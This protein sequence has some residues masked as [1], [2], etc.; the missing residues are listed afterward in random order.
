DSW[1]EYEPAYVRTWNSQTNFCTE[2]KEGTHVK[3]TVKLDTTKNHPDAIAA[4]EI[5]AN[6]PADYTLIPVTYSVQEVQDT[7]AATS[8]NLNKTS[9][10]LEKSKTTTLTATVNPSNA[11]NKTVTWKSSN[12]KVATVDS[13]GKIKAVGSGSAT[14][15]AET[16][17]GKKATCKVTVKV[18]PTSIKLNKTS[19][20]IVKGKTA[21]ITA[22]V[23]PSNATD[24]KVT[25]KSS[26]TKVATVDSTGKITAKGAGTATITA[27]TSNSK[28]A[29]C[30]VTVNTPPTGVKLNKTSL[31]IGKGKTATLKATVNPT[32]NVTSKKVT[33]SSS[34]KS[35][36]TVNS[37]GKITAK[38]VGTTTITVKTANG[39]TAKCKVTVKNLPSKVKLNKTKATIESDGTVTLKA[40]VSPS[41]V[42]SKKV[43]WTSSNKKVAT[44]NSKGKVTAKKPGTVTIT[45]KTVNGKT[46][47]CKVTVKKIDYVN[48]LKTYIDKHSNGK[49]NGNKYIKM[50]QKLGTYNTTTYII[51]DKSSKKPK[52]RFT[53]SGT[54]PSNYTKATITTEYYLG[55]STVKPNTTADYTYPF[56]YGFKSSSSINTN[57]ITTK[58]SLTWN[59]KS[60]Y[61]LTTMNA[62]NKNVIINDSTDTFN[63]SLTMLSLLTESRAK[64]TMKQLGF[65]KYN[66]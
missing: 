63:V 27:T 18:L 33:W 65:T 9:V 53:V 15:T 48:R 10:S 24:K 13:T 4:G 51:N 7:V 56:K 58:V 35:V 64:I 26:N 54:N 47:K 17:N 57:N 42:T 34:K 41:N 8:I 22:T 61:G 55:N 50:T 39:K 2:V 44:V 14:I 21:K 32:K 60:T 36:A 37:S 49:L 66:G 1:G 12:T 5:G 31:T 25:W 59:I 38:K 29:T 16:I 23:S 45:A 6:E 11:T 20:T 30:K 46:A 3:I 40:T 62:N 28:K 19:V 43:T 52:V